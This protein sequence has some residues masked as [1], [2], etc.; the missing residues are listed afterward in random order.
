MIQESKL[1]AK[2]KTPL[3]QG[4]T[5]VRRDRG[6]KPN[7]PEGKGGGLLTFVKDD[8]PY[9]VVELADTPVDSPLERLSVQFRAG[10]GLASELSTCTVHP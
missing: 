5:T 4:F 10:R 2:H 3:L 6:C 8:I 1:Q 9:T 7:S